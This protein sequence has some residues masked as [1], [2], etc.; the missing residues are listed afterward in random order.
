M[1]E[2][3][4]HRPSYPRL[5]SGRILSHMVKSRYAAASA[6]SVLTSNKI[7]LCFLLKE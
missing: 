6:P 2:Q 3:K 5:Y 7:P 4:A 1:Y